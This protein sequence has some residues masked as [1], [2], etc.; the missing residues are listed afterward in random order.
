MLA[1]AMKVDREG[2]FGDEESIRVTCPR[3]GAGYTVT[4][5]MLE[6]RITES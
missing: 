5:E 3:C 1:T 4:R 6:K 2:I